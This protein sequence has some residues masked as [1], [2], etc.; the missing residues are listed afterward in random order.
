MIMRLFINFFSESI[1]LK[2]EAKLCTQMQCFTKSQCTSTWPIKLPVSPVQ[3]LSCHVRSFAVQGLSCPGFV[4]SRVCHV[5]GL[6]CSGFVMS[7]VCPVQGLS[8]PGF[9]ISRVGH[10]Q[11]LSCPVFVMSRVCPVQGLLCPGLSVYPL[12]ICL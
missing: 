3:G 2:V 7:R 4:I 9:V 5:Q 11:G 8:C 1:F 10:V 6:S 12:L